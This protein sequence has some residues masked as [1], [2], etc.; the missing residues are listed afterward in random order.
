MKENESRALWST[1]LGFDK[2]GVAIKST[3]GQFKNSIEWDDYSYD[4]NNVDYRNDFSFEELQSLTVLSYSKNKAYIEESEVRF[5]VILL[6][7]EIP[8][9]P[10]LEEYIKVQKRQLSKRSDNK[11]TIAFKV[12]LNLLVSDIMIS[13]YC[14]DWQ[15]EIIIK[16]IEDYRK[17]LVNKVID[18]TINE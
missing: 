8:D 6:D 17:D 5:R 3:V 7:S 11:K 4:Y 16:L 1:Y 15:K 18:S 10:G 9:E 12:D 2:I 14:L 13:P